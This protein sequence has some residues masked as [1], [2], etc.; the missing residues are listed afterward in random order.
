MERGQPV[1]P[2]HI[3]DKHTIIPPFVFDV[4]NQL[5]SE[6][7]NN[8]E[9]IVVQSEVIKRLEDLFLEFDFGWLDVEDYYRDVGWNVYYDKPA[10]CEDYPATFT[11]TKK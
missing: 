1:L 8:T 9:A 3:K 6:K 2:N 10:Y 7:W 4:F 5:I 11:F